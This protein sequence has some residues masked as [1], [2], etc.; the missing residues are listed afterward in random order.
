MLL[1]VDKHSNLELS[2]VNVSGVVIRILS[3]RKIVPFDELLGLLVDELGVDV[4][5]VYLAALSFLYL[6][7]KV[8][9]YQNIDSVEL[10]A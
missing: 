8:E 2:V 6:L 3:D 4:K 10:L 7:G 5:E 9:Y 1:K